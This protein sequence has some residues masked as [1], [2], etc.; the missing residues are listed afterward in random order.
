M[1]RAGLEARQTSTNGRRRQEAAST[2]TK[3][4]HRAQEVNRAALDHAWDWF[5]LHARQRM[6]C[7][8]F[9]LVAI[10]FLATAYATALTRE[11]AG[12]AIGISLLGAWISFWFHRLDQR[13]RELVE[14]GQNALKPL[15]Q[16]LAEAA[17]TEQLEIL[18]HVDPPG[19][20]WTSYGEVLCM[21]HWTTCF[22]FLVGACYAL[23]LAG[24][25][26]CLAV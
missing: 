14:A 1:N 18:K 21:L 25:R 23:Y 26:L 5:A 24:V 8:N 16:R 22:A 3:S 13:T 2:S 4:S 17:N 9:F 11:L 10:A 19:Q 15:Q 7:V 12:L 6:Q 20:K